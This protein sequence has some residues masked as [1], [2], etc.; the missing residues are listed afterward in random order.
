MGNNVD[1][2]LASAKAL[3]VDVGHLENISRYLTS[4]ADAVKS[5]RDTTLHQAHRLAMVGGESIE[6]AGAPSALGSQT[7][8]EV[9]DLATRENGTF[10]AVDTALKSVT[11]N[12]RK[13]AEGIAEIAEKYD[14]VEERNAVTAAQ[15]TRAISG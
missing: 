8:N 5:I 10:M 9:R 14:T 11:D 4:V 13:T 2:A 15:W 6:S 1:S 3:E 12:L 7:I